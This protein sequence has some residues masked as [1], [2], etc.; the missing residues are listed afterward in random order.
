[1]TEKNKMGPPEGNQN[2]HVHGAY[3]FRD[4]GETALE[5]AGRS[6]FIELQETVSEKS[7]AIGILKEHVARCVLMTELVISYVADK[8]TQNVELD[9]IAVF[10]A[11]P[12]FLNTS[13]R[14][15]KDLIALL[16][17]DKD[18]LDEVKI[19]EALKGKA[20]DDTED[21]QGED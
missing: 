11:L 7:G 13:T 21:K 6:R 1:M 18:V 3:S 15:L 8:R 12:A 14:A 9:K 4:N 10:K 16:P 17:N 2:H 5:L 20:D 19:L